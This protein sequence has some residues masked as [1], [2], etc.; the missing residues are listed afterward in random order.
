[1]LGSNHIA[2]QGFPGD[3]MLK[4]LPANAGDTRDASLLPGLGRSPGVGNGN[5]LQCSCL[6][7]S[8]DRGACWAT[9]HGV[10]ES[11]ITTEQLST[12]HAC[13]L[14]AVLKAELFTAQDAML[15]NS[16][17]PHVWRGGH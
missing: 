9:V 16:S 2:G 14:S 11:L 3:A 10:A 1:M 13:S 12:H 5:P 7:N 4:N 6:E 15:I 17:R 8:M